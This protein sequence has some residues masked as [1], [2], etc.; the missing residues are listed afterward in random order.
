MVILSTYPSAVLKYR[1]IT[2]VPTLGPRCQR[3]LTST[4]LSADNQGDQSYFPISPIPFVAKLL[5]AYRYRYVP[6]I[7]INPKSK[8]KTL[9]WIKTF[10]FESTSASPVPLHAAHLTHPSGV[11]CVRQSTS[12]S[13]RHHTAP[14]L[15]WHLITHHKPYDNQHRPSFTIASFNPS[16]NCLSRRFPSIPYHSTSSG[17]ALIYARLLSLHCC[18]FQRKNLDEESAPLSRNSAGV[19][20]ARLQ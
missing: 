18:S 3:R 15:F 13:Y 5:T 12:I 7:I 10:Q 8:P 4:C 2:L 19:V 11:T 20:I 1:S 9:I 16:Q 14:F 6:I 17:L